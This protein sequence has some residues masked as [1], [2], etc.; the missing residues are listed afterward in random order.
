LAL[1]DASNATIHL[2]S[3]IGVVVLFFA[4]ELETELVRLVRVGATSPTVAVAGV[5]LP[6]VLGFGACKLV[7]L[8]IPRFD[9]G[10]GNTDCRKRWDHPR[11]LSDLG[12][13]HD[14]EG[15]NYSGCS[16]D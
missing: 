7:G 6:F 5:V 10:Q 14:V 11:V 1:V 16:R 13:L 9:H 3:E 15:P 4:I 12:R 8:N 2:L